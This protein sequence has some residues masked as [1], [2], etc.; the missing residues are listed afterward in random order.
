MAHMR[1]LG[2][3]LQKLK[4]QYGDDRQRLHQAMMELYKTEKVNPLGGCLPIVVQ[5]PVFIA[6]YWVLLASVEMRH[7]PFV[8]WIQDLSAAD[9]YYRAADNHGN[10]HDYPD[11]AQSDATRPDSGQGHDD[12]AVRVQYF[13]LLLPGRSGA[14]LG[15]KQHALHCP[16]MADHPQHRSRN[17][18][19]RG[20]ANA[21]TIAAVATAPGRGGIGVVRVSGRSLERIRSGRF[22]AKARHS[23]CLAE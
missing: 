7:A 2:P 12:H 6:L 22:W 17:R 16:A 10:H 4:E 11:Q 20:M 1:V 15:G 18:P 8:L 21:D 23:P 9:P 14:L 3:K 19:R 5:I 13:L